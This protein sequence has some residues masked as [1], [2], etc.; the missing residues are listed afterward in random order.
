MPKK[1]ATDAY[2]PH[3]TKRGFIPRL[4]NPHVIVSWRE[5]TKL[6]ARINTKTM[7]HIIL[8]AVFVFLI[9]QVSQ[10][11]SSVRCLTSISALLIL[12][13]VFAWIYNFG[14]SPS[15][16]II[17]PIMFWFSVVL[18][19]GVCKSLWEQRRCKYGIRKRE[20]GLICKPRRHAQNDGED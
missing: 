15:D 17:C 20:Y 14:R 16:P 8:T 19:S 13:A 10:S 3:W 5:G 4:V 7:V 18:R 1:T 9:C 6:V 11:I 2:I 12:T